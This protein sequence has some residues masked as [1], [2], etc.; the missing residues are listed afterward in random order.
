[1]AA[2]TS[3]SGLPRA[4][5]ARAGARVDLGVIREG[6]ETLRMDDP[7]LRAAVGA[8][9]EEVGDGD[10]KWF[11]QPAGFIFARGTP[12]RALLREGRRL[13]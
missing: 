1:M 5:P 2:R 8:A 11:A 9:G 12:S 13:S 7:A 4:P 3:L 10:G 6:S